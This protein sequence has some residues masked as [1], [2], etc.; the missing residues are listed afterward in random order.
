MNVN[1][2]TVG[3]CMSDNIEHV[4]HHRHHLQNV[5]TRASAKNDPRATDRV[6]SSCD[7]SRL[8]S[9]SPPLIILYTQYIRLRSVMSRDVL[10]DRPTVTRS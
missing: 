10:R 1:M 8:L 6:P 3:T 2:H 4:Y 7:L 5:A 9:G